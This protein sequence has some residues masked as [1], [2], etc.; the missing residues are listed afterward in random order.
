MSAVREVHEAVVPGVRAEQRAIATFQAHGES[1]AAVDRLVM[2]GFPVERC[3]LRGEGVRLVEQVTGRLRLAQVLVGGA[4]VGAFIGALAGWVLALLA[5]EGGDVIVR[6]LYA[7]IVGATV[8]AIGNGMVHV[9]V[10]GGHDFT[11]RTELQAERYLLLVDE[12]VAAEAARILARPTA[13]PE[14]RVRTAKPPTPR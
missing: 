14:R 3:A 6:L 12:E 9:A 2:A 7:I 8:G 10:N 4:A 13:K 11:S 5:P 1:R